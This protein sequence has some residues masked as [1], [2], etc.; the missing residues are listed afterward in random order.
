MINMTVQIDLIDCVNQRFD[1]RVGQNGNQRG[2][3]RGNQHANSHANQAADE[4]GDQADDLAD[5]GSE[6]NELL[7]PL[8]RSTLHYFSII[9]FVFYYL[10]VDILVVLLQFAIAREDVTLNNVRLRISY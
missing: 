4:R 5:A 2:N 10:F 1:P 9:M 3:Q 7:H 8:P 6:A